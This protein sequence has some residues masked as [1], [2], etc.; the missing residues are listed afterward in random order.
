MRTR[1]FLLDCAGLGDVPSPSEQ[2]FRVECSGPQF[3]DGE[4]EA[5]T[6][7]V[8]DRGRAA[9]KRQSRDL[10][11]D[12]TSR[13]RAASLGPELTARE[14]WTGPQAAASWGCVRVRWDTRERAHTL[15]TPQHCWGTCARSCI[16]GYVRTRVS[17]QMPRC[18]VDVGAGG[19]PPADA[20]ARCRGV[21]Q[22]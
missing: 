9:D 15:C 17:T 16:C 11:L 4:T 3:I 12:H 22:S 19:H 20:H 6:G 1:G 7:E 8:T 2:H 18:A 13:R 5:Q 21:E 14:P 10:N